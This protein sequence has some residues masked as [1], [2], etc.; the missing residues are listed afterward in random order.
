M[1]SER[2]R[3]QAIRLVSSISHDEKSHFHTDPV[4]ALTRS[5]FAVREVAPSTASGGCSVAGS[6]SEGPPPTITVVADASMGRRRFTALHEYGHAL[7]MQDDETQDLL[8]AEPDHGQR[9]EEEICDAVAAELLLPG[10]L[11]EAHISHLGPT[12]RSVAELFHG[13]KASREAVC[14]RAAQQIRG[15]GHVMLA[16]DGVARFTSS[17]GTHFRVSR[18][19]KQ[20]VDHITE[21]ASVGGSA[22]GLAEVIYASGATSDQFH[23]DA[24]ADDDGY[25]FAVFVEERPAWE[26][27]FA[28]PMVDRTIPNEVECSHCDVQFTAFGAPCRHCGDYRHASGC[29]R[30]SCRAG[31][32]RRCGICFTLKASHLFPSSQAT[33]CVDCVAE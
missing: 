4:A 26:R 11:V 31:K 15:V 33:D 14:V 24:V 9:M 13:A 20:G 5:G 30:C 17:R 28:P 23:A 12:A 19:T 22:R 6:Y 27:N 18:D 32:E 21:R 7:V 8:F 10:A 1:A 29:D 3:R 16:V 25:V 2:A